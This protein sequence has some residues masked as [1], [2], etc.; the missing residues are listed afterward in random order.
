MWGLWLCLV[1]SATWLSG[2]NP[3]LT[4]SQFDISQFDS[5]EKTETYEISRYPESGRKDVIR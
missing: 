5:S 4:I 2:H 1:P 3:K